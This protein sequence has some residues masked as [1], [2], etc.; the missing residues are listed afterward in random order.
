MVQG[1]ADI[2]VVGLRI[3][4]SFYAVFIVYHIFASMRRHKRPEKPLL[5]LHGTGD[6]YSLPARTNEMFDKC[7][8]ENKKLVWFEDGRH[9]KLRIV[10]PERYDG[11]IAD[12]LA[13]LEA[14]VSLSHS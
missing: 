4:L 2:A 5:M 13:T 1:M 14:H 10:Y 11:A 3:L 7:P 12:F 6:I 9:S 8:S